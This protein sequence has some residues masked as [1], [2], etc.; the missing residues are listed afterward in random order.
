[1]EEEEKYNMESL[2]NIVKVNRNNYKFHLWLPDIFAFK[3]G[4]Q[5]YSD[6]FLQAI[7]NIYQ[8]ANYNVFLKHDRSCSS[9][10]QYLP[11]T[12]FHFAGKIPLSLRTPFFA[13]QLI[14]HGI[15][16]KPDLVISTHLN[17]T[18]AAYWL[19]RLM[20]I[21]YIVVVHGVE[22][23][24][25]SNQSKQQALKYADK[26]L[27]VSNYT[28]ERLLREEDLEPSKVALLPNTFDG[29]RFTIKPKPSYLL[30]RHGIKPDQLIILTVN[31][32]SSTESYRGYDYVLKALPQIR[33]QIP[34][35]HYIIVGKGDDRD[36]LEDSIIQENL[37]DCVTLAGFIS[38]KE[39]P[40]YYQLCDLFAMPS[41]LEGFGIVYL[42]ALA[43][44]KPV[45]GGNQDGA[46]DALCQGELGVLVDPE[47]VE[48]I[49]RK[50]VAILQKSYS[51]P[52]VYQA[53]KLRGNVIKKFGFEMFQ[54][55]L[56]NLLENTL[57]EGD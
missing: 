51:H 14:A 19:K 16:Q 46:I 30:E 49:A 39:L 48:E 7:Q 3:G 42:E 11:N 55:T 15:W 37:Q 2:L 21:P 34:N 43:C 23:W 32:L 9:H 52:L 28:R 40:A 54:K 10:C 4:V 18:V 17:F 20:G 5:V 1:M 38:D 47:N 22:A 13:T 26:I 27:A 25:I 12:S 6:F 57:L 31:R 8:E 35:V 41:K 44:G 53:E 24:N 29:D 36:R 33:Q 56:S 45:L 50:I